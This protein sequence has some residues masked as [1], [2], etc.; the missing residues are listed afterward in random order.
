[1][2]NKKIYKFGSANSSKLFIIAF[3]YLPAI[4]KKSRK[5]DPLTKKIYFIYK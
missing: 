4:K 3:Q 2:G 1:M 5:Y